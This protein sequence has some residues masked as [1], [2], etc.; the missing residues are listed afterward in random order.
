MPETEHGYLQITQTS[1]LI[2]SKN[3]ERSI[4]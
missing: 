3:I 4:D 2:I 1:S